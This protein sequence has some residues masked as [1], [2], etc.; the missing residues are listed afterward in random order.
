MSHPA[1]GQ[2]W[3]STSEPELGL[4]LLLEADSSRVRLFF[5]AVGEMRTYAWG[6]APLARFTVA[7][8]EQVTDQQGNSWVVEKVT[9]DNGTLIYHGQGNALPESE[10]ADRMLSQAPLERLLRGDVDANEDFEFR[11][12]LLDMRAERAQDPATGFL[13]GRIDFL[14]H[15]LAVVQE[16]SQRIH[17]RVLL[18]D[19]V[20]LGKTIEAGLLI[21]QGV[22][23]GRLQRVLIIVPEALVHQ[24]FVEILRRFHLSFA[25]VDDDSLQ[26]SGEENPFFDAQLVLC[27]LNV[28]T[29][30]KVARRQAG[31]AEWDL[32][33][34]DEAHHLTWTRDGISCEYETVS[35]I[36][37]NIPGLFLLTATPSQLG[38]ETYFGQLHLLDPDRYDSFDTFQQEQASYHN[39]A[40]EAEKL[41]EQKDVDALRELL[42]RHGP[43]RLLFRNT[44]EQ[45]KGFPK[46]IAHPVLLT[47][48]KEVWLKDFLESHVEEK[49]LIITQTPQEVRSIAESIQSYLE[50]PPVQFHEGQA[51][52]ERDRQAAWFADS[53]GS[54]VM[55]ASDIGG[56]GRNFQF[57]QHLVLFDLPQ[58]PERI[59]QR[60]GRLDRI[61]QQSEFHIHI[62]VRKGEPEA[63]WMRWLHEGLDAFQRP[64]SCAQ[65]CVELF[66]D[67]LHHVDE[68]LLAETR[69]KVAELEEE[70][71]SGPQRLI[72]LKHQLERP[73]GSLLDALT[74]RDLDERLL[75][76]AES[77]WQKLGVEVE[78]LR[79]NEYCGKPGPFFSGDVSL[80]DEG[81]LFTCDRPFATLREDVELVTWDH[82]F[83]LDAWDAVLSSPLGTVA[84]AQSADRE[85]PHL[86]ALFI[87]EAIAPP[88]LHVSRYFPPTPLLITLDSEGRSTACTDHLE[89]AD[90]SLEDLSSNEALNT[91]LSDRLADAGSEAE[92]QSIS[93]IEDAIQKVE[94]QLG[95]ELHRL[96][97]LH[98]VNDHVRKEEILHLVREKE[99]LL[100][101]I[102]SA[103][104][105]L[106]AMRLLLPLQIG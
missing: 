91:W 103:R 70:H 2:R 17:P 74:Q 77:L 40:E 89:E 99:D 72:T 16:V 8:G 47:T 50:P 58:N 24:W 48:E 13:G 69:Q 18:A 43:S 100:S 80:R 54:R 10:L 59:E 51:L 81:F 46:R 42:R 92:K 41:Y 63:D 44:R 78:R 25:I 35:S 12:G 37:S 33:V 9:E 53:D 31:E 49:V 15:Q 73:S 57:V 7:V 95:A 45:V 90:T 34:V 86:Q 105:R 79:E 68:N 88:Q 102:E 76:F 5:P 65:R 87:L 22:R 36:A 104:P 61:G 14:E 38:E 98:T 97:D 75:P 39:V 55:I 82:P 83:L 60:I 94:Q 1:A 32:L 64:L 11:K 30:S 62:P 4:G 19:E 20:G 66:Q 96:Q 93:F 3:N 106:E 101:T 71:R 67:R 21:H 84:V 6:S 26:N 23:T 85:R 27:S 28:L 29:T 52:L 56:E